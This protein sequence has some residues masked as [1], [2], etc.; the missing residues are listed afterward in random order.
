MADGHKD[1]V[2]TGKTR[3]S[4]NEEQQRGLFETFGV[5]YACFTKVVVE[6][7]GDEGKKAIAEAS[8]EAGKWLARRLEEAGI[9]ERGIYALEKYVYPTS[10][11][12]QMADI[13]VFKLE[14]H[15][16]DDNEFAFKVSHCPYLYIWRDLSIP[17]QCYLGCQGDTG[18]GMMFDPSL[19]MTLEK[20]INNGDEYC[21]YSWKRFPF[22]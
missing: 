13:G 8:V 21:I 1:E 4:L 18:I 22:V 20:C 14:P 9:K 16:L 19:R 7:F 17:E 3:L 12:S 5:V 10:G 15:K 11:P 6:K 2:C